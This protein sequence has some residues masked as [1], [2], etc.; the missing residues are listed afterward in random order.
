MDKPGVAS[1][2]GFV[3]MRVSLPFDES[4]NVR[5]AFLVLLGVTF[6]GLGH[7]SVSRLGAHRLVPYVLE[8]I[9]MLLFTALIVRSSEI[10]AGFASLGRKTKVFV[11]TFGV[12]LCL[13]Q[14]IK[15]NGATFPLVAWTMYGKIRVEDP[16]P[17]FYWAI[18]D[19]GSRS[20]VVPPHVFPTLSNAR[21]EHMLEHQYQRIQEASPS[22]R[23]VKVDVYEASLRAL[24]RAYATS[25]PD[26]DFDSLEVEQCHVPLRTYQGPESV[27]CELAW[28]ISLDEEEAG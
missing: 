19:D 7:Y 22:E 20:E 9:A 16:A 24:L 23:R 10:R 12:L 8:A 11:I 4:R 15:V 26:Q 21:I 18:H 5:L 25:R 3:A 1:H 27:T 13:G 6:V 2:V 17:L 14:V 28:K